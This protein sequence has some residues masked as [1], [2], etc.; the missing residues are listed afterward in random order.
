[1]RLFKPI[2][3]MVLAIIWM[4]VASQ[5]ILEDAELMS[6]CS[7]CDESP[8]S[9]RGESSGE[10]D[11][12]FCGDLGITGTPKDDKQIQPPVLVFA[13]LIHA[14]SETLRTK[15][16]AEFAFVLS[17]LPLDLLAGWQFSYRAALPGRAP[18]IIS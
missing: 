16:E 6:A 13:I 15:E 7:C 1:M 18:S 4:P 9:S 12:L 3:A 14:H 11:C 8:L 5:C 2:I 10:E 17:S